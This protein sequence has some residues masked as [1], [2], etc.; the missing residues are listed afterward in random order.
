[1]IRVRVGVLGGTFDPIHLGHLAVARAAQQALGLAEVRF[2]PSHTP[3]HRTDSPAASG[4]HRFAMVA[5]A[6]ADQPTWL[7]SDVELARTGPSYTYDTL[8]AL[9]REGLEPSQI[10]FM[11]GAD[12]FAEV[13]TW[14]RYPAVLDAAQF[15]VVGRPGVPLEHFL[16]RLPALRVRLRSA[17]GIDT[18]PGT[19]IVLVDAATPDISSTDIRQRALRG[20]TIAG[21]VPDRVAAYIAGHHL[22]GSSGLRETSVG[23][24]SGR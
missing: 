21:F 6:I 18:A 4:Y 14:S 15:V 8:E 19:G 10:F 12:A 7:A 16:A 20:A 2:V 5:L 9:R 23:I 11:T 13:A 24:R 22:Y 17:A 1:M 3:P